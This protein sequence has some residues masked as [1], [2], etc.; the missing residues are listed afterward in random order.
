MG[1]RLLDIFRINQEED[2]KE[3]VITLDRSD[4]DTPISVDKSDDE[5]D[6]KHLEPSDTKEEMSDEKM[7]DPVI[8]CSNCH[9]INKVDSEACAKCA[10]YLP[11]PNETFDMSR[12]K[13]TLPKLLD[14]KINYTPRSE[15]PFDIPF[16]L[17]PGD[18]SIGH[19]READEWILNHLPL[20]EEQ[21]QFVLEDIM[22]EQ[23]EVRKK[24]LSEQRSIRVSRAK[25]K[26]IVEA[27][28][29][30]RSISKAGEKSH[31]VSVKRLS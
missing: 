27:R 17:C 26:A 3:H 20:T 16:P 5:L 23:G 10:D 30:S 18:P 29:I 2:K 13:F 31:R 24:D 9:E 21:K 19:S 6:T 15:N 7:P 28:K 1:A 11:K 12:K 8:V 22:K 4:T 25:D 14:K